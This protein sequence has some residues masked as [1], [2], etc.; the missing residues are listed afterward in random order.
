MLRGKGRGGLP[1]LRPARGFDG[2]DEEA[3]QAEILG[4]AGTEDPKGT[5][6]AVV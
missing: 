5:D 2:P 6:R 4:A 1:M 3:P